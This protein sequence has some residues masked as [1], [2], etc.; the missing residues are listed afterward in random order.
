MATLATALTCRIPRVCAGQSGWRWV[1][2]A[3]ESGGRPGAVSSSRR[4]PMLTTSSVP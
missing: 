2:V 1:M 3:A 4:L